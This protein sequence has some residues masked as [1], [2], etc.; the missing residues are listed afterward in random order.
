M[1]LVRQSVSRAVG[2]APAFRS[3][4]AFAPGLMAAQRRLATSGSAAPSTSKISPAD[5]IALLNAQRLQRPTSP[6]LA[7]YQPQ[8]TWLMSG[9]NRI[10]GVFLSG[11][12]Y[13]GSILYL[14][15]PLYPALDSAHLV[16]LVAD[17]PVWLKASAKVL[18]AVP[19]TYHAFNGIRHLMWDMGKGLTIKGVYSTGYA[20]MAA[21]AVSSIYLAFFV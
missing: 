15:H 16:A 3:G 20:V 5:S 19:F 13:A 8:L 9:A 12:L 10:T 18:F 6:H 14:L 4:A 7:I 17:M 1:S 21:T 11:A 2:A